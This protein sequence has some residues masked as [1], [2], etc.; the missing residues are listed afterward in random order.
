MKPIFPLRLT[1]IVSTLL[2]T[3]PGALAEHQSKA[4]TV[5]AS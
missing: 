2:V 5:V 3:N 4:A 1:T